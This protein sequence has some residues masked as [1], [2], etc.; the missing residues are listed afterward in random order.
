MDD[1]L[2]RTLVISICVMIGLVAI[3]LIV[4]TALAPHRLQK[5]LACTNA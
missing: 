2:N 5:R 3:G 1:S 4:L